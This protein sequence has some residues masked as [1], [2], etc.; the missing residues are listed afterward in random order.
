MVVPVG[1][2]G[3]IAEAREARRL[4]ER[5]MGLEHSLRAA[6]L[7]DEALA[8]SLPPMVDLSSYLTRVASLAQMAMPAFGTV[9]SAVAVRRVPSG[10]SRAL[11][12]ALVDILRFVAAGLSAGDRTVIQLVVAREM[13]GIVVGVACLCPF[14]PLA[15]ARATQ[16]LMRAAAVIAML[17]GEFQRGIEPQRMVFGATLPFPTRP[18]RR[19]RARSG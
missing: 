6:A 2:D 13:E 10:W 1:L 14:S 7:L 8:G 15:P 12:V 3:L 11:A 16:G 17:G 19:R 18:G 9:M 4:P 5:V